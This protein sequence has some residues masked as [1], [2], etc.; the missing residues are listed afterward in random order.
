MA[1]QWL[2]A[3]R[4]ILAIATAFAGSVAL[5][6][7]VVAYQYGGHFRPARTEAPPVAA[8]SAPAATT[9]DLSVFDQPR[10]VPEI[11]FVDAEGRN[12][13]LADFRGKIILLNVWATW[14]VPCRREMPALDRLQAQLGGEDFTVLALSIDRAG[15]PAIKRF[16]EELGLQ[17][18]GI[19]VDTSGAGSRALGAPGLPTTLLIDRAGREVA[20][21]IGPA[22]WGDPEIVALI[23]RQIDA[24]PGPEKSTRP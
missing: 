9:L 24:R 15:V 6:L 20:R 5:I 19:Y 14:C 16:Y 7:L 10:E 13:T 23:R 8:A 2:P 12:L 11:R 21:K 17:H 18:L 22:E 4:S 1:M 3:R